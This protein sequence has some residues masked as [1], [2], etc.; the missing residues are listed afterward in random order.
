MSATAIVGANWGDE[1]KGKTTDYLAVEADFVVRFQGGGN[2]G[3][4]IIN[5]YGK[6]VLH[7]LPSGVFYPGVVNVLGPG[8]AL[9]ISTFLKELDL[10][11]RNG[12]PEPTLRISTRAQVILPYH[13]LLDKYEEE[14]LNKQQFGSTQQGIAPFYADKYLK[15]GVQVADL[16]EADRLRQRLAMALTTKN[17]FFEHLYHRP[18]LSVDELMPGLLQAGER[19]KPFVCDTTSLLHEALRQNKRILLEGQLGALR[20]PDHGIYPYSTS[21]S[22]LAGFAAVGAGIPPYAIQRIVAVVKAYSSCVGTGPFVTELLG[23]EGDEL[24]NRGGD[25]GEYGATT[26]RPRRVGWFDAVATRYGCRVQG[27]TEVALTLLDVLGYRD[28]IPVC[29]AYEVEGEVVEEFPTSATLDRARPIFEYWPGWQSD[30]SEARTF[31]DL[32]KN[33]QVYT[34]KI[35]TLIGVPIK[36]ISV[37]PTREAMI[38]KN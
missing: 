27:A 23:P 28:E 2:A 34:H 1:G 30:I 18:T 8:V 38:M 4:T 9:N 13:L 7:L 12:V 20:D 15:V 17:V 32:P 26:G 19:I 25:D 22:P 16:F 37:G 14:R 11:V 5:N 36:W 10:L 29:V 31:E 35:E 24:R 33:A 21:S 3:H 6:F